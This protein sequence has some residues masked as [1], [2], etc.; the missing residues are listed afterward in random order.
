MRA[1]RRSYSG[2][3]DVTKLTGAFHD[4]LPRLKL[5]QVKI[6]VMIRSQESKETKGRADGPIG[7]VVRSAGR[8]NRRLKRTALWT[9]KGEI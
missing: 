6:R 9:S 3:T 5:G 2:R 4:M 1:D 8:I 7:Y